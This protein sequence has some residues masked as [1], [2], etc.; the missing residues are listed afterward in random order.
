MA[1]FLYIP[2]PSVLSSTHSWVAT[3]PRGQW[4]QPGGSW[5]QHSSTFLPTLFCQAHTA[6]WPHLPG[7]SELNLVGPDGSIPLHS[8]PCSVK[9][10]SW[11]AT[12]PRGQWVKPSGSW[13]KHS[14]TFLPALFCQAHTARWPHLP[15]ASELNL[16]GPDGS[17]PL[18]SSPLCS[19]KHTQPGGRDSLLYH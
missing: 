6:G 14:S 8:S 9:H 16:V 5:W 7:A 10:Y 2:P 4:V 15:G 1:A 18:H 13:C 3:S 12:S 11:V 17:I 19:V